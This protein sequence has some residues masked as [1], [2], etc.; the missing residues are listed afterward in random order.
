MRI[1]LLVLALAGCSNSLKDPGQCP[2]PAATGEPVAAL[3][4]LVG[5]PAYFDDLHYAPALGK[6]LAAP[7]GVARMYVVDPET[8]TAT[9]ITTSAGTASADADART[10]FTV[11][12][13]ND[14]VTAYDA[15]TGEKVASLRLGANPDYVRVVPGGGELW[16]TVPGQ[17]RIDVIAVTGAP[18]TLARVG[19]IEIPGAPEGLTFG[20]GRGYT[21]AGGR[22]IAVDI[23]RRLVV[24]EWNTGCDASHGFAQVDDGYGLVFAG[25]KSAG[26]A[27]VLSREGKELTGIEAGGTETVLAYDSTR[28]HL[29]LRGD[30]G[31]TLSMIAVCADGGMSVMAEV[32][33]PNEGHA[34]TTDARGNVW[35]ADATTGG[36]VRITDPFAS[37][38]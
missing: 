15:T 33:I 22:V 24:G 37:T 18:A 20:N 28:H 26:G 36:L 19:S 31:S 38:E 2:V 27:A 30:P 8:M 23:A 6:V 5:Q 35:L 12:R 1:S 4:P 7:E 34:A 17:D 10:I 11:D 9:M 16:V 3:V 13:S 25:C 14:Q 21:Q 29:H 32:P